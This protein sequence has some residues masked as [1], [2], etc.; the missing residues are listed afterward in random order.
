MFSQGLMGEAVGVIPSK[1]EVVAPANGTVVA[2]AET[3]HAVGIR[4][5]AGAEILVHVGMDTVNLKGEGFKARV[6]VGEQ[7][8]RGQLLIK[9][10]LD[11]LK[12]RGMETTSAVCVTNAGDLQK[13]ELR[14]TGELK[15]G[16]E[17]GVAE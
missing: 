4:T 1:G 12:E 8:L 10:D 13:V 17:L 5:D 14:E 11:M 3:K 6:K 7:V 16:D 2:V 15:A 9:F